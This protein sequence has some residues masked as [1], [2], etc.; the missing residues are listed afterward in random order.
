MTVSVKIVLRL[1]WNLL[2]PEK[3]SW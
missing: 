3:H 2:V 1:S